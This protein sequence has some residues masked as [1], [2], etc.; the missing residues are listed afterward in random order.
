M[1]ASNAQAIQANGKGLVTYV[2]E[3]MAF[4]YSSNEQTGY[5]NPDIDRGN[6]LEEEAANIYSIKMSRHVEKADFVT[7]PFFKKY[8]GCTPDYYVYPYGL[9]EIKCPKDRV[10]LEYLLSGKIDSKYYCQMQMQLMVTGC[11]WCDYVV[12][13]PNFDNDLIVKTVFPD[14]NMFLK[15]EKG[16][17]SGIKMIEEIKTKMESI[18]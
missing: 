3:I 2:M 15:L 17:E 9:M 13:N 16:F 6:E 18:K 8:V 12:Y 7:D 11:E 10:F 4:F 14:Y 5:S 1:T